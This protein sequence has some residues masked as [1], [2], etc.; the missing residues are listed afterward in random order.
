MINLFEQLFK[1][2]QSSTSY[3]IEPINGLLLLKSKKGDYHLYGIKRYQSI[4]G[5]N[6]YVSDKWIYA[7][8]ME[9]PFNEYSNESS[10]YQVPI[11]QW[12]EKDA[13]CKHKRYTM[14]SD[15][16]DLDIDNLSDSNISQ[17]DTGIRIRRA[18]LL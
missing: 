9:A 16:S 17:G 11:S 3:M 5:T 12:I 7:L 6:Q 14:I 2:Y 18:N 8:Y 13:S 10:E 1:K 4:C 15:L